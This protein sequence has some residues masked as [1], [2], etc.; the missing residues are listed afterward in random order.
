MPLNMLSNIQDK[1]L[2]SGAWAGII[3]SR[4][5]WETK[6]IIQDTSKPALESATLVQGSREGQRTGPGLTGVAGDKPPGS[7]LQCLCP[8]D[9]PPLL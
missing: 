3:T 4:S 7:L 2:L 1:S 8:R 9:L 6:A 5:L